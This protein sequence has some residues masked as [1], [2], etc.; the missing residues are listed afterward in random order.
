M[1]MIPHPETGNNHQYWNAKS[2]EKYG[3][4]LVEQDNIAE[5]LIPALEEVSDYKYETQRL[6][7]DVDLFREIYLL[8]G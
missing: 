5:E 8:L 3:H 1:I 7:A 4:V 2:F 6:P